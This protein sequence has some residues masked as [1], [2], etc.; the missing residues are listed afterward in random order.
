MRL[1]MKCASALAL[2]GFRVLQALEVT[3]NSSC[4]ALCMNEPNDDPASIY[5]STTTMTDVVCSDWELSGANSTSTGRKFKQC[6]TC[7]SNSTASDENT[8]ENDVNWTLCK[9]L[10]QDA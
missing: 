7:E 1:S 2:L 6:L 8:G 3:P 10:W 9:V 4:A 5:S